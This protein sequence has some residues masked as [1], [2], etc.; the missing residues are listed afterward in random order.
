[1][2]EI[3]HVYASTIVQRKSRELK[4]DEDRQ[5][6]LRSSLNANK[7][8]K[9][10]NKNTKRQYVFFPGDDEMGHHHFHEGF[11]GGHHHHGGYHG[12][13][14]AG[15]HAGYHDEHGYDDDHGDEIADDS[16]EPHEYE[17]IHHQ[18]KHIHHVSKYI[19][20]LSIFST[21]YLFYNY[22]GLYRGSLPSLCGENYLQ[23]S[24][25][26]PFLI[27]FFVPSSIH[28]ISFL[29]PLPLP[30]ITS[31]LCVLYPFSV[32]SYYHFLIRCLSLLRLFY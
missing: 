15:F 3:I 29:L 13:Y 20:P 17:H 1:M 4:S 31:N 21:L 7:N 19:S 5:T 9:Q 22:Y 30:L 27:H 26:Y 32:L 11:Y 23:W 2:L 28:V 10:V 6:R 12:D 16:E 14:D 24:F 18:Y 8:E 25:Y